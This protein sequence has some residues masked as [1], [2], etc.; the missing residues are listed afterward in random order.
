MT[1]SIEDQLLG[2][3]RTQARLGNGRTILLDEPLSG[4]GLDSLAL[5]N[6]LTAVEKEFR[7]E[8]PDELWTH[9][10]GMTIRRFATLVRQHGAQGASVSVARQPFQHLAHAG[11]ELHPASPA[12]PVAPGK[13]H[14][15]YSLESFF[16]LARELHK[17]IPASAHPA[18]SLSFK[19]ASP[20][21]VDSLAGFWPPEKQKRKEQ[22]F[23]DRVQAGFTGLTAWRGTEIM[24]ID[25]ISDRGDFEPN[26]GLQI[27]TSPG[28][29]YGFDLY[30]K[31]EGLG[32]GFA[33]LCL[34][35]EE[36]K[37]RGFDRQVTIVS[38]KNVRMMTV[39][40]NLAGYDVVGKIRTQRLGHSPYSSW[41]INGRKGHGGT[42]TV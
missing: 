17:G 13:P 6:F 22:R 14:Q 7:L 29:A 25:W 19:E 32:I 40:T 33:L 4:A 12:E 8:L 2:I 16:I 34:S 37:N 9:K 26:T 36:C 28:T 3:L 10:D 30:E 15:L 31:Y 42:L 39:A 21:D 20:E 35:L 41:S 5:L 38:E 23:R 27:V 11:A 18:A 24:G 1:T